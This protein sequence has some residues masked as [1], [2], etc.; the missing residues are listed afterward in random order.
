MATTLITRIPQGK[1]LSSSLPVIEA[2]VTG[3]DAVD[4]WLAPD[5]ED[6]D[7]AIFATKLYPFN[8]RVSVYDLT[9]LI[10]EDMRRRDAVTFIYSLYIGN[11][12]ISLDVVYCDYIAYDFDFSNSFLTTMPTQRVYKDSVVY[13]TKVGDEDDLGVSVSGIMRHA[14]DDSYSDDKHNRYERFE[15]EN[16]DD[17]V[18]GEPLQ[19]PFDDWQNRYTSYNEDDGVELMSTAII[20][21]NRVKTLYF[22]PGT[23]DIRLVFR[24]CF[25][26]LETAD[27]KGLLTEKTTVTQEVA[28]IAGRRV[29]YNRRTDKEYEFVS[30]GLT[31]S[32]SR[33]L[34]QLLNAHEAWVLVNGRATPIVITDHTC[35][36]DN[37][38]EAQPTIKF[39]WQFADR[40]PHLNI[41]ALAESLKQPGIFTK[42]FTYQFS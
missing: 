3:S 35:E 37:N 38:N 24:N 18:S 1:I 40:K 41:D 33:S 29:A 30:E 34:D 8:G 32:E 10:E 2:S 23:P 11:L 21:G 25:N 7:N 15:A 42:E 14:E 6:F 5:A 16:E 26:A 22:M 31:E 12:A 19:I 4:V 27:L 36:I 17:L 9:Q 39:T 20:N 28:N 13:V